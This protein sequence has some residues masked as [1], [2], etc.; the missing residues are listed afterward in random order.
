MWTRRTNQVK[1]VYESVLYK[2]YA[3]TTGCIYLKVQ[4]TI[5]SMFYSSNFLGL[6]TPLLENISYET[7]CLVVLLKNCFVLLLASSNT[8]FHLRGKTCNQ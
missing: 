7:D 2:L 3:Q 5:Q 8:I 4:T 6:S 1:C